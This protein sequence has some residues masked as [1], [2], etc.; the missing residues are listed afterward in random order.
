MTAFQIPR[1]SLAWLFAA[2]LAVIAPH[3]GRLPLWVTLMVLGCCCWRVMVY[4]G[5]WSYPGRWTKS[6]FVLTGLLALWFGYKGHIYGLE[7]A[8]A[9]LVIA[10]SLKLLEMQHKRDAYIVILLGY[11]VVIT[12]FLFF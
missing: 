4:K 6:L 10:F 8:V 1:N 5:R 2:Q 12:E 9:L 11:F 7:P 3:V